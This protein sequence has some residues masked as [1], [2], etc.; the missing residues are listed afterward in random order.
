M[1]FRTAYKPKRRPYY[2]KK[3]RGV[4]YRR[5]NKSKTSIGRSFMPGR[6][7]ARLVY[8]SD[9]LGATT[10]VAIQWHDFAANG[11][12]DPD[13][14]GVGHQP[15][16]F[17]QLAAIYQRYRV[18]ACKITVDGMQLTPGTCGCLMIGY[19]DLNAKPLGLREA[20]EQ[21]TYKVYCINDQKPF[22]RTRYLP[23]GVASGRTRKQ[24]HNED[25]FVG[26]LDSSSGSNPPD[27]VYWHVGLVNLNETVSTSWNYRITLVYYVTV[28]DLRV[29]GLS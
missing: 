4:G 22:R 24:V 20:R 26:V 19:D 1:P 15:M 28:F 17:D 6:K 16:G 27:V 25:N 10:T 13:I 5:F 7:S 18:N 12:Y 14:T 21:R 23:I 29:I 9:A 11:M 8:C 2:R 3:K